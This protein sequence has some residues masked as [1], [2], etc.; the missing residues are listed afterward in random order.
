MIGIVLVTHGDF[1]VGLIEAAQMILGDV[2][3]C[4]SIGIDVS[5][6][7]DVILEEL[8]DTVQALDAGKGVLILTDMFGGTPTNLSLSLLGV[9][10]L[11]VITG[12]NLPM[13]LKALSSRELPLEKLAAEVKSA[14]RQGIVVAGEVLK[15][16]VS[17]QK[18]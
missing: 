3:A 13:L 2:K 1:G 4:K 5:K 7:M 6:P 11:E 16:P 14:G 17:N 18:G 9:K 12:V 15:R 8:K 10:K